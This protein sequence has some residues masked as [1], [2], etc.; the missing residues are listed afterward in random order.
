[1]RGVRRVSAGVET[2]ETFLEDKPNSWSISKNDLISILGPGEWPPLLVMPFLDGPEYSV[3]VL[4]RFGKT[5]VLPRRRTAIR[6]GISMSTE[7]ELHAETVRIVEKFV[8]AL[9]IEGVLGFQFIVRGGVPYVIESNP[10]VQG[11]MVASLLSGVNLLWLEVK[12]QLGLPVEERE[13]EIINSSGEF[14][15]TWSGELRYATGEI[16]S[17]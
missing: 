2:K 16:E 8:S 7:L 12:Y 14:H 5:V 11:T 6:A 15:R 1:M 17:I 10:R 4:R 3:D 13:L 9:D